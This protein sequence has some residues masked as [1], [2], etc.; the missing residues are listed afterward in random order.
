MTIKY[1]YKNKESLTFTS[2]YNDINPITNVNIH[3]IYAT[4]EPIILRSIMNQHES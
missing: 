1:G 2:V 4:N 3:I